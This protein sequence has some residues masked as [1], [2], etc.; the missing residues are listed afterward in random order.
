M[1][2]EF[3]VES[4]KEAISNYGAPALFNTT[5]GR[6]HVRAAVF[7]CD[8]HSQFTS[9]GFI[10]ILKKATVEISRDGQGRWRDNI[11]VERFWRSLMYE[12]IYL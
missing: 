12:Y 3:C 1:D 9:Y 10:Q 6:L 2:A 5:Q 7:G 8:Q 11:Y 4:L